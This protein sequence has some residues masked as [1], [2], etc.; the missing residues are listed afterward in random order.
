MNPDYPASNQARCR[1]VT[2]V[3][4]TLPNAASN[5]PER[6]RRAAPA[7]G[8]VPAVAVLTGSLTSIWKCAILR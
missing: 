4:E 6:G 5:Q 3:L 1:R 2:T 7:G 8:A